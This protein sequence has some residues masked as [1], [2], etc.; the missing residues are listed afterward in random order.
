M[1]EGLSKKY[2]T[3]REFVE[4]W[5]KELYKLTNLDYFIYLMI[6]HMGN[7]LDKRFF[8]APQNDS[9]LLLS[10]ES[11]GTL[12]FNIGDSF[13]YFLEEDS[14]G[15]YSVDYRVDKEMSGEVL[16]RNSEVTHRRLKSLQALLSHGYFKEHSFRA[17]LMEYVII[18]TLLQFY[19]EE[20]GIEFGDEDMEIMA[21]AEYIEDTMIRF[22]RAEGK[23]LLQRYDDPAIDFF[24][25]LLEMEE[26]FNEAQRWQSNGR[27]M[28]EDFHDWSTGTND[29]ENAL[30]DVFKRFIADSE[31]DASQ[32]D[33]GCLS[34]NIDLLRCYLQA[35]ARISSIYEISPT[36]INEFLS[37][38]LI[39]KF[40]HESPPRFPQLFQ[41]LARFITWLNKNLGIEL[42]REFIRFYDNV[43]TEIPRVVRI[44]HA[45]LQEYNLFEIMLLR[46]QE[47]AEQIDGFFEIT[48]FSQRPEKVLSLENIHQ[49]QPLKDVVLNM[50]SYNSLRKGDVLQATVVKKNEQWEILEIHYIFPNASKAYL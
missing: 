3:V 28:A 26:G 47:D 33:L 29:Q 50:S 30:D 40:A 16:D 46:N 35:E 19:Y 6:N 27:E 7:Q 23:S 37:V 8:N 18:D 49:Y 24:E 12:C 9:K 39:K 31:K 22:I 20:I 13:E 15:R 17:D 10:F 32:D 11:I 38:W 36:H 25:K 43:K 2:V 5:D 44:L 4:S 41:S 34:C 21:L 48:E 1:S 42:K 45:Y 14:L